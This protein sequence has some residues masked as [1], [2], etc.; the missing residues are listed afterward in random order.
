MESRWLVFLVGLGMLGCT[1]KRPYALAPSVMPIVHDYSVG[2]QVEGKRCRPYLFYFIPLAPGYVM[3]DLLDTVDSDREQLVGLTVDLQSSWWLFGSTECHIITAHQAT[4]RKQ[5]ERAPATTSSRAEPARARAD[6]PAATLSSTPDKPRQFVLVEGPLPSSA[7]VVADKVRAELGRDMPLAAKAQR[8]D[9]VVWGFA[10]GGY[11]LAA[12][13]VGARWGARLTGPDAELGYILLAGLPQEE[14]G[15]KAL[16]ELG[17]VGSVPAESS[18]VGD[19]VEIVIAPAKGELP[20]SAWIVAERVL[21][22]VGRSRP[23]DDAQWEYQ[24]RLVWGC[25]EAG[26]DAS[27]IIQAAKV[28]ATLKGAGAPLVDLLK[29]GLAAGR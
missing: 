3:R 23:A 15:L 22:V 21:D 17:Y 24:V 18:D 2:P 29:A 7:R 9:R 26:Y 19:Q 20:H 4:V 5:H 13:L 1:T 28:G 12:I 16:A 25:A 8:E 14:E 6:A 27:A 10:M 11:D